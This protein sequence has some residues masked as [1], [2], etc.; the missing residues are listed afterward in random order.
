MA[1]DSR[2]PVLNPVL[3]F[4]KE[5]KP[6][7]V[8][9]GGKNA[10]NIRR[11]RLAQQRQVL[12]SDISEMIGLCVDQPA[13]AGRTVVYASMFDDS[14]ATSWRPDDLFCAERGARFITPFRKGYLVEVERRA[15]PHLLGAVQSANRVVDLVDISRVEGVRFFDEEDAAGEYSLDE[16]WQA[17][18][19]MEG[20]RAFLIWLMPFQDNA[21]GEELLD[22]VLQL[23]D[24]AILAAPSIVDQ[25]ALDF[26]GTPPAV[27][28][29]IRATDQSDTIGVAVRRYRQT[30]RVSTAIVARTRE[31]LT[32]LVASGAVFRLE[33]VRPI[34]TTA[35]GDG[36]EPLRPLPANMATMP[37]VGVV[38]GGLSA[39]SYRASAEAWRAP[40]F[41]PDGHADQAHGNQVTSL[42]VQGHDWNNNLDLIPLYCRVGTVQVVPRRGVSTRVLPSALISYLDAVMGAYPETKVWNLS[43]NEPS[44]GSLSDVSYLGHGIAVLARKHG[45]LPVISTGNQPGTLLQPPADCEAAL[46]AG[47]R[48]HDDDGKPAGSCLISLPGPGPSGMLKPEISNFSSVRVLGGVVTRGSSFSAAL[49]SPVAAHTFDRLRDPSPDLVKALVLHAAAEGPHDVATGFGSPGTAPP[50]SAQAGFVTLQWSAALRPGAAYYWELPVPP[51]LRRSGK[52]KGS[53]RLTAILNPHPLVS[54]F[55]GLNYFGARLATAVQYQRGGKT[56]NLLGSL[57]VGKQTEEEARELDHKW[58]PIRHHSRSFNVSFDGDT[59]SIYG[60]VFTRDLYLHSYDT[61][62]E[63]PP[64]DAVFVLTI[65]TG[66]PEDDLYGE[67]RAELGSFVEVATVDVDIDVQ[68]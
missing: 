59:L 61:N 56:Q 18:P 45:V 66:E 13:F 40:A 12:A 49:T 10:D 29:A 48:L 25:L 3:R 20:G 11:D 21:A 47:G 41:I 37:I 30:R 65:G 31:A 52:L 64:L 17:A 14:L 68:L 7:A 34:S 36:A 9:G 35:P 1:N 24:R 8:V 6:K 33:P 63:V 67:I 53:A 58:C 4:L 23:R 16:A 22:R 60:R 27:A 46:T 43:F 51:A 39:N 2:T 38:D 26:E 62:E 32:E 5:A 42:I 50:W 19:R 54:D 55:A 57:Q 28:R 15:L 44:P